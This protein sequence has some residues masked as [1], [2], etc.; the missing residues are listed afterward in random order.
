MF[1]IIRKHCVG[2]RALAQVVQ[3]LWRLLLGDTQ[4]PSDMG[5]APALCVPV[6]GKLGQMISEFLI[7][8]SPAL[9]LF[10]VKAGLSLL[11][12][13]KIFRDIYSSSTSVIPIEDSN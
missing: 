6:L 4:K 2:D 3:R 5:L 10:Q 12:F 9:V 1:L 7:N 11:S 13:R 8:L